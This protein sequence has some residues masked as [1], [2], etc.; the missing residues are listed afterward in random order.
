MVKAMMILA[1]PPCA[2]LPWGAALDLLLSLN[3]LNEGELLRS[4]PTLGH[5]SFHHPWGWEAAALTVFMC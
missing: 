5:L 2:L 1:R 3:T 4:P